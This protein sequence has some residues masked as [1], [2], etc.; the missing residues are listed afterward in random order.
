MNRLFFAL[1][2]TGSVW[3]QDFTLDKST[4]KPV[5]TYV[6]ELKVMRGKAFKV[7][8]GKTTAIKIGERFQ[9]SDSITTKDS[10]FVRLALVDD[11]VLTLGPNSEMKFTEFSFKNKNDR[12][13]TLELIRGQLRSKVQNKAKENQIIYKTTLAVMGVRGTELFVNHQVL[14]NLA[15]SEFSLSEG[16][17]EVTDVNGQ[18]HLLSKSDRIIVVQDSATSHLGSEKKQINE[19]LMKALDQEESLM[20]YIEMITLD[21][22]IFSWLNKQKVIVQDGNKKEESSVAPNEA[23]PGWE[24][25]LQKLNEQLKLNQRRR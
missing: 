25:N 24:Q 17:A 2:L 7:S 12:E 4:G 8:D 21:H 5:P 20:P 6:G 19:E 22:N 3:A 13:M 1:A 9:K 16:L 18:K 14:N 11:T 10:A 15:V 23:S